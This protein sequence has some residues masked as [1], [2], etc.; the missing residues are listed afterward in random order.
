MQFAV[1]AFYQTWLARNGEFF[2]IGR[3]N[4]AYLLELETGSFRRNVKRRTDAYSLTIA[5]RRTAGDFAAVQQYGIGFHFRGVDLHAF[6]C[7][8]DARRRIL[9]RGLARF[10]ADFTEIAERFAD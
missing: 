2:F 5:A 4:N 8:R 3:A 6:A 9:V 7:G 10:A 1:G